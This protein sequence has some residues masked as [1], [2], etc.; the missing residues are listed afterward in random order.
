MDLNRNAQTKEAS[1]KELPGLY[2]FVGNMSLRPICLD[3]QTSPPGTHVFSQRN[4]KPYKT[5]EESGKPP[6]N[7]SNVR[8]CSNMATQWRPAKSAPGLNKS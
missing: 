8:T 4:D 2:G 6:R 3:Y 7:P 1:M 5:L